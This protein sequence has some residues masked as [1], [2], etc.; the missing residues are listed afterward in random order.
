[1]AVVPAV[2]EQASPPLREDSA[3]FMALALLLLLVLGVAVARDIDV[4]VP[5]LLYEVDRLTTRVVLAAMLPPV[6]CVAWRDMEVN[7][8][9]HDAD[10]YRLNDYRLRVDQ[11]R[12][13]K[14]A[15]VNATIEAG[16][17]DVN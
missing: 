9:P 12:R 15:D 7:R 6:F 17:A 4:A 2:G 10:G 16:F 11:L 8:L 14:T 5:V 13:W 1:M 3:L